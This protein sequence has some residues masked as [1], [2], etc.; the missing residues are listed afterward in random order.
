M[1]S[2]PHLLSQLPEETCF[3]L[4]LAFLEQTSQASEEFLF[5]TSSVLSVCDNLVATSSP[6]TPPP[7][8]PPHP[9]P[10]HHDTSQKRTKCRSGASALYWRSEAPGL[11]GNSSSPQWIS[12]G[13]G[14]GRGGASG[15]SGMTSPKH[16]QRASCFAEMAFCASILL[17][18]EELWYASATSLL[19]P[20]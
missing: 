4:V 19:G 11:R 14:K 16:E 7:P 5:C 20:V 17:S 13:T 3:W 12:R 18:K 8:P 9:T 10:P 1:S 2:N 15:H 6:P